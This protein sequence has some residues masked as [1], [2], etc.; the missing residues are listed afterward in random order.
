MVFPGEKPLPVIIKVVPP[1]MLP[2]VG[3]TDATAGLLTLRKTLNITVINPQCVLSGVGQFLR[4]YCSWS[5]ISCLLQNSAFSKEEEKGGGK[6]KQNSAPFLIA[7]AGG[8]NPCA[9]R[10]GQISASLEVCSWLS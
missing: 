6:E 1:A 3:E 4:I 9:S 10:Q 8:K 5:D 7:C 2:E